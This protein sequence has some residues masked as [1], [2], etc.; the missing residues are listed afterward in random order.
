LARSQ[1]ENTSR[2][3]L[4]F[5]PKEGQMKTAHCSLG[6]FRAS[7]Y[8][9]KEVYNEILYYYSIEESTFVQ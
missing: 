6:G 2:R 3:S 9:D 4:A 5:L 7:I 8:E 1:K